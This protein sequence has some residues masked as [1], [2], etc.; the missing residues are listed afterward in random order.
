MPLA[1]AAATIGPQLAAAAGSTDPIGIGAWASIGAVICGTLPTCFTSFD[2]TKGT[3]MLA[4]AA[5]IAPDTG[6]FVKSSHLALGAA[7]AA[8]SLS[9]DAAGIEKWLNIAEA[10]VSWIDVH[11]HYSGTGLVAY[12]GPAPPPNG[13][14]T[15]SG[16]V[17]FDDEN[18]GP[19]L[20]E[21]AGSTD[22]AGIAKWTAI[23]AVI[24]ATIKSNGMLT[25]QPSMQNPA[26]GGPVV[27]TATFS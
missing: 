26:V 12:T 1:A 10:L 9:L 22:E 20:A 27:G 4:V 2:A 14:V 15:G 19:S 21:A 5:V 23:G 7:L 13:A 8:A 6:G 3:P 25:P 17:S 24:I 16:G 18:V 11:G